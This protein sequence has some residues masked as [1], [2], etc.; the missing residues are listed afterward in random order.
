[1]STPTAIE[2][3]RDAALDDEA[4]LDRSLRIVRAFYEVYGSHKT[5]ARYIEELSDL[6]IG[7]KRRARARHQSAEAR[8]IEGIAKPASVRQDEAERRLVEDD[9]KLMEQ[10]AQFF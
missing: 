6:L 9:T 2:L 1:M 10:L 7:I 5:T 3:E 8:R 4:A